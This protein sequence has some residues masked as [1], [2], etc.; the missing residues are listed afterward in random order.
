MLDTLADVLD[1]TIPEADTHVPVLYTLADVLNTH[2]PVLY[3]LP[4]FLVFSAF[5]MMVTD[6]NNLDDY[7]NQT[8]VHPQPR[9]RQRWRQL[10]D[11]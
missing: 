8:I 1:T 2:V 9:T 7:D 5:V 10:R 3:T 6:G 4:G 11:K